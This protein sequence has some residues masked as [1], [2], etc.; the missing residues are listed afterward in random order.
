MKKFNQ[1]LNIIQEMKVSINFNELSSNDP[2]EQD[3]IITIIQKALKENGYSSE[4][5]ETKTSWQKVN[6]STKLIVVKK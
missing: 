2:K 1:Y 6:H 4:V 3:E 5:E